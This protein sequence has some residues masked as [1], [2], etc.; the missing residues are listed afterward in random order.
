MRKELKLF[1]LL[2]LSL[3]IVVSCTEDSNSSTDPDTTAPEVVITYPSDGASFPE[4]EEIT[5]TAEATD[6]RGM[7][8]VEFLIDGQLEHTD[9]SSPYQYEWDTSD[10]A[11][12]HTITAKAY[13]EAG[14]TGLSDVVDVII[15]ETGMPV[16]PYDPYPSDNAT[17]VSTSVT[18]S[19]SCSDPDD[20]PLTYDVY[21]GTSSNPTLVS[22]GQS[23]TSYNPGTLNEETTYYW[24]IVASD[25]DLETEGDVWELTTEDS[26]IQP[27]PDGFVTCPSGSFQ[28]G[29][30][31]G[32]FQSD[33]L[34]VHTVNLNAFYIGTYEVTFLEVIDVF[35]WA[36]QRGY[37]N[38]SNTFANAQGFSRELLDLDGYG[39]ISWNGSQLMFYTTQYAT[40]PLCPCIEITWYGAVAYCN[41]LSLQEGLTPCYDLSDWSCNWSANGYRLPTEAEW[42]YAAR[43]CSN[44]PDYL[45]A[46]SDTCGDVAWYNNNSGSTIHAA[47]DNKAPVSYLEGGVTYNMSGNVWEWC[48]DSY[49]SGYYSSSPSSNP[50]GPESGSFRVLRGGC[51]NTN[52]NS[53]RVA[54]R[55]DGY[56]EGSNIYIGFRVCRNAE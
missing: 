11:G 47:G 51:R 50:H 53:C 18:L 9:S 30:T 16:A 44:D 54:G 55:S 31:H 21:F 1:L 46:G 43:G 26:Y 22:S 45:Y 14:N 2:C 13:D 3:L 36:Y 41:Y 35:N 33:E 4:G 19:W 10:E 12:N 23:V 28:M 37:V 32:G 15:I 48:W 17:D 40:D 27:P 24:K 52:E 7:Q 20:D 5:I 42:E 49:S 56:Q 6:S 39:A 25:G 38:Y 8:K 29:D 34:P